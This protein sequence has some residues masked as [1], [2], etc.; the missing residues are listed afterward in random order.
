MGG[1]GNQRSLKGKWL[2]I[3]GFVFICSFNLINM[4][5]LID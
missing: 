3:W 4:D 5:L 1:W 2:D